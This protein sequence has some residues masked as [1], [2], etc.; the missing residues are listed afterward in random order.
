MFSVLFSNLMSQKFCFIG[1]HFPK[2]PH[3]Q[4]IIEANFDG[5]IL[6]TD[7]VKHSD[8]PK[9]NTELAWE[10]DKKSLHQHKLQRTPIKIQVCS[11][12]H[13]SSLLLYYF[14]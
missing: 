5:E 9:F 11:V 13:I 3:H 10:I 6:N 12:H 8:S 2:R 4:L 1:Q 7:S 14:Q